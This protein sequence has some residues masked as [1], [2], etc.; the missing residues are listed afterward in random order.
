LKTLGGGVLNNFLVIV[1]EGSLEFLVIKS[2][3]H[4]EAVVLESVLGLDLGGNGFILS[5]E[6][7]GIVDHLFDFLF[8]ESTFIVGNG[9]LV[10]FTSSLIT[11]RDVKDTVG[12]NIE[13]N[14]NLWDTSGSWWNSLK[15]EFTEDM[16]I[17]GHFSLSFKDLNEDT[18]LVISVGGENLRLFGWDGSVSLD[19]IGHDTTGGLDTHGK[20]GDI[21]E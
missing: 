8:G 9:N 6:F 7:L 13:S 2:V 18:W 17:L 12:I 16:V 11:G 1:S 4:L 21:E 15:V 10:L 14:L 20:W 3:L 5:L 19:D